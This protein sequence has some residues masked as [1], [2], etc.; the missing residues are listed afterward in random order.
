ME[1]LVQTN[2]RLVNADAMRKRISARS[3]LLT[4]GVLYSLDGR[5]GGAGFAGSLVAHALSSL[6]GETQEPATRKNSNR[7]ADLTIP[8]VLRKKLEIID[9]TPLR[10]L[11]GR[12]SL[13]ALEVTSR[14]VHV[15]WQ[16]PDYLVQSARARLGGSEV[17][18]VLRFYDITGVAFAG[19]NSS[20]DIEVSWE[21]NRR[22]VEVWEADREYVIEFGLRA[23]DGRF[24]PIS[25]SNRVRLPRDRQGETGQEFVRVEQ[26]TDKIIAPRT[27]KIFQIKTPSLIV[28]PGD[29]DWPLR[30]LEA[31]RD[32]KNLYQRFLRDGTR[33][34][35]DAQP[36]APRPAE[37]LRA[38]YE[39][40]RA[41]ANPALR[42]EKAEARKNKPTV[43]AVRLDKPEPKAETFTSRL[44]P[45][46]GRKQAERARAFPFS[47]D[48]L[49]KGA[50]N[51][52]AP[53]P[54]RA[55][56]TGKL[57]TLIDRLAK[58]GV[59]MEAELVLRGKVKPG[60]RLRIGGQLV[61]TA[62]DGSFCVSC[63]VRDG[64]LHVPV[65]VV[66]GDAVTLRDRI[67]VTLGA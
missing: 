8:E 9:R 31:E 54:R 29:A 49:V 43:F 20:F 48:L 6:R 30:D 11:A 55:A 23:G 19:A 10:I 42:P 59:E 63:V 56:W 15:Y 3:P 61:E 67:G 60:K 38:E 39:S 50:E 57:R 33:V 18:P 32:I 5:T 27:P 34:L 12:A 28:A 21:E 13:A 64:K 22:Y 66:E 52:T 45:T 44:A 40:R 17:R 1:T 25:R 37:V 16:T 2:S 51:E 14:R 36:L 7:F 35:R 4:D 46:V 53:R 62:P 65:E 24:T 26:N 58:A 41:A 47:L